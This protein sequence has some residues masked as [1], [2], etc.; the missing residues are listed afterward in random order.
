MVACD[1]YRPAA[2]EQLTINAKKQD[3]PVFAMGTN[4]KPVDIVKAAM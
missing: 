1:I 3:V 2:I 4:H